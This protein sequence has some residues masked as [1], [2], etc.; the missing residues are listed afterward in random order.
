M[1]SVARLVRC[2]GF[3]AA[4]LGAGGA[5][6]ARDEFL[7]PSSGDLSA[8]EKK[9]LDA[10]IADLGNPDA[11]VR[12]RAV[13]RIPALGRCALP[14]LNERLKEG[15]DPKQLRNVCLALG[16]LGDATSLARVERWI[17]EKQPVEDVTRA[18][19]F[20]LARGRSP[21]T[22]ELSKLLR[23]LALD[24]PLPTVRE[25]AL[26]CAGARKVVGLPEI[27]KGPLHADRGSD[28]TARV[29]G[30]SIV[31]LA[32]AGD[33][34][35]APLVAWF[36]DPRNTRDEKLR[37][38]A[39]YATSR[40]AE[41]TQLEKLLK[42]EPDKDEVTA[43]AVALGA[44][45]DPRAVDR[46]GKLLVKERD[47]AAVAV[48]SLANVA[49][50]EAKE[51]LLRA[52]AGEFSD[53]TRTLA[54]LAVADLTDQQRFLP[55]LRELAV[56]ASVEPGKAAALLT[57]AR[58]GDP[59]AAA[60]VADA[61]PL[62][63]DRELLERG[64]LLCAD[65]LPERP[66]ADLVPEQRAGPIAPLWN[67]IAQFQSGQRPDRRFL[68]EHVARGLTAARAHWL[69]ARDDLRMTVVRELLE[70]DKVV[71][72]EPKDGDGGSDGG[73]SNPPP[74]GDGNPP[75]DGGPPPGDGGGDPA[76]PPTGGGDPANPP[77][78]G[79]K[80]DSARFE[81][82]LRQ[83]LIDFPPFEVADPFGS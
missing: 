48:L 10:R 18:A 34:A 23:S 55:R 14:A 74:P 6:V 38:A 27:L 63:R 53:K 39:L 7:H 64:L 41:P 22:P 2:C 29:R 54:A 58:V 66:V 81:L 13:R 26:L 16:A 68:K 82:D 57:L 5:I 36:L 19:L 71:F 56:A 32:E 45:A 25:S 1:V 47:R 72:V 80:Q 75:P 46:L 42:F 69:L 30:C 76:P 78:R 4:L 3:V 77:P 33:P 79:R 83:W 31:A 40:L 61:L 17:L 21:P 50:P 49:T 24:A 12:Q 70:L 9:E 51:W 43:F 60:T 28:R 37:R 52:L 65:A 20:A 8:A 35:G 44:F 15:S 59:E 11:T 73:G 67:E 62:W